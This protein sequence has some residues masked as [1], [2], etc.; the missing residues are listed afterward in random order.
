MSF[1]SRGTPRW[2]TKIGELRATALEST[3]GM[4]SHKS[5]PPGNDRELVPI[6]AASQSCP[7]CAHQDL[8]SLARA[9]RFGELCAAMR[10]MFYFRT[11][12]LIHVRLSNENQTS[13]G[14]GEPALTCL[15]RQ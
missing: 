5:S 12:S 14:R 13:L 11:Y 7:S 4:S 8:R 6:T 3:F 9:P 10:L 15:Y 1:T 2:R